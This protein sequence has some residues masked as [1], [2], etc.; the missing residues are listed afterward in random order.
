[1]KNV[2]KILCSEISLR[3]PGSGFNGTPLSGSS[4]GPQGLSFWDSWSGA[5]AGPHETPMFP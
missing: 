3:S 1:M 5:V 4:A 2:S